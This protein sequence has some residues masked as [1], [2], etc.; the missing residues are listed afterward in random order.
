MHSSW[1]SWSVFFEAALWWGKYRQRLLEH[2]PEGSIDTEA[3]MPS[4]LNV[5][6]AGATHCYTIL[7]GS[8]GQQFT[9]WK[10]ELI[11]EGHH[12]YFQKKRYRWTDEFN[13]QKG[14]HRLFLSKWTP[15]CYHIGLIISRN[16]MSTI[17]VMVRPVDMFWPQGSWCLRHSPYL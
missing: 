9:E 2:F 3:Q 13:M 15:L 17:M 5:R 4:S 1:A 8:D 6:E 12:S 10:D 14:G 16:G 11:I 7:A